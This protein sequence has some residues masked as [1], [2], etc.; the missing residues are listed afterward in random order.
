M[1]R[2]G[3]TGTWVWALCVL[4]AAVIVAHAHFSADLSAFLPRRATAT[5]QLLVEQLREG[6]AAHLIIAAISGSDP[7]TRAEISRRMAAELR[8]DRSF[9]AIENGDE[10]QL[11]RDRDFL[12]EHRYLLS[13]RVTPQRFTASGLHEA[14]GEA[15]DVLSSAAGPLVKPLFLRDPTLETLAIIESLDA[16]HAPYTVAGVWS[17]P[18]GARAI[19]L[20]HTSASGADLDGQQAACKALERSFRNTIAGL[21]APQRNALSFSMSGPPVFAVASRATIKSQVWRLSAI[22]ALCI[23]VLL[24]AVYRS[25][26]VLALTLVPVASGALAGVAAVALG[27][28]AVHGLTLGFGVTLIGESVDYAIYLFLQRGSDFKQAVWPTIRLGVLTSICGFAA[29]L[30]SA[31]TGLAQLGLYSIAGL[32]AAALV[33]RYVLAAWQLR[34][35]PVRDLTRAGRFLEG[36]IGQV[37]RGRAG[38]LVMALLAGILLYA[39]R[40][41]LWSH[42]LAAL[43]PIRAADMQ[44]DERLRAD[45]GAPDFRYVLVTSASDR[46]SAL[47][48]ADT[49]SSRLRSL[50]DAGTLGGFESPTLFLPPL[51]TQQVR[52]ASLP[53]PEVLSAHLAEALR[54]LPLNA[55][56]LAPFVQDIE[57]ARNA[58]LLTRGDLAGTSFGTAVDALLVESSQGWSVLLPLAARGS[59]DLPQDAIQAVRRAV[60]GAAVPAELLD[61]KGEADRLY[62]GYLRDAVRLALAGLIAIVM[63]LVIALRSPLRVLRV[64]APLM[65]SVLTVAA[66]LVTLGR[67]LTILHVVGMLLIVAVGSN[68]ALFFDR[69]A[70]RPQETSIPLVLASLLTA[71]LA[72]VIAFGV[73]ACS[74]V[75]VLADLGST[76]APGTFLALLFAALLAQWPPPAAE[77][78]AA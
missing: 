63:L 32:I 67:A 25:L 71:N 59:G 47:A 75:P 12:F 15:L 21:P 1:S 16:S 77:G 10:A 31:F 2:A 30:P 17:S 56:R 53:L 51:R 36:L 28:P 44:L 40:S 65:L 13:S 9:L 72:T 70:T 62:S 24:L 7:A 50:V 41:A 49:L 33:T 29:L 14:I 18:D 6:L 42:E 22:S 5:Q 66:I 3:L 60:A 76:V 73:L 78:S 43:S 34:L 8:T 68:Y 52:R 19:I 46:E 35:Q 55:T 39:H 69:A 37:R 57:R 4:L 48:A 64:M 45:A 23:A 20:A 74:S 61:L 58:G 54:G 11:Q 26:P 38:L 27:F